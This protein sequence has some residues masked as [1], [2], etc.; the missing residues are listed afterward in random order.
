M[1]QARIEV[2][3]LNIGASMINNLFKG[4]IFLFLFGTFSC[5]GMNQKPS[6]LRGAVQIGCND[7]VAGMP[8]DGSKVDFSNLKV[9]SSIPNKLE[10][11]G[12][13]GAMQVR[14]EDVQ[15]V[16]DLRHLFD[17]LKGQPKKKKSNGLFGKILKKLSQK[18]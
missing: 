8:T 11:P 9:F 4:V 2:K 14:S 16:K 17:S 15:A 1:L 10:G 13:R 12:Y 7:L 3:I 5:V 18:N 6:N